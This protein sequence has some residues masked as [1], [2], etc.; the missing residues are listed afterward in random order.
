MALR[1]LDMQAGPYDL[2]AFGVEP[3]RIETAAGRDEYQRRQRALS[4]RARVLR[5]R[6]MDVL[7]QV[8]A[9]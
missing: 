6:L 9:A 1:A 7:A 2:Q 5:G 4:A 8:L 3:V